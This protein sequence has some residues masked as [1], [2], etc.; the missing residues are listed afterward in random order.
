MKREP[1]A[2][3]TA[4]FHRCG[5]PRHG[6]EVSEGDAHPPH[7]VPPVPTP[8]FEARREAEL[9][10]LRVLAADDEETAAGLQAVVD[11]AAATF[12]C[13]L[14]VLSL[15]YSGSNMFKVAAGARSEG[16]P[17]EIPRDSAFCSH[18][19]LSGEQVFKV[20]DATGDCRF[21]EHPQVTE[22]GVRFY[23]GAP[24]LAGEAKQPIG[25]L[26]VVDFRQ[27]RPEGLSAR[28][29]AS[30]ATLARLASTQLE[31]RLSVMQHSEALAAERRAREEI[32]AMSARVREAAAAKAQLV[33]NLSHELRTPLHSVIGFSEL[34]AAELAANP[35]GPDAENFVRAVRFGGERLLETVNSMLSLTKLESGM[36]PRAHEAGVNLPELLRRLAGL[37]AANAARVPVVCRVDGGVPRAACL[38]RALLSQIVANL[39]GNAVK[40]ACGKSVCVA[41][42]FW[43]DRRPGPDDLVCRADVVAG[44][45]GRG[46]G[47]R[48]VLAVVRD[49]VSLGGAA[50]AAAAAGAASAC[51]RCSAPGVT[52]G[53]LALRVADSGEGIPRHRREAVFTPF[54]Q[55]S[56]STSRTHGGTGLGLSIT[57]EQVRVLGGDLYLETEAGEGTC[58]TVVLPLGVS[59][60][61]AGR[62]SE[63][64]G[65]PAE[66]PAPPPERR[67]RFSRKIVVAEDDRVAQR[68]LRHFFARLGLSECLVLCGDGASALAAAAEHRP[69]VLV[70]DQHMPVMGGREVFRRLRGHESPDVA[71][72]P[73]VAL[74]A[75]AFDEQRLELLE[76]GFSDYLV[77][78]V[79]LARLAEALRPHQDDAVRNQ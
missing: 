32:E 66:E 55:A 57:R 29:T 53:Y 47:A 9:A 79:S 13:D 43:P 30:L 73:V 19:V 63:A 17:K 50:P 38:D 26:A 10:R 21:R 33:A 54:E 35:A 37:H 39:V 3:R 62:A 12:D 76:L 45:A 16:L 77:K 31:L 34:L 18:A 5:G 67:L 60:A 6:K 56:S 4:V 52:T 71:S 1:M 46:G 48:D 41:A 49:G 78:P 61:C 25:V 58:F 72:V 22:G 42:D 14:A 40:F 2:M 69:A 75:D 51:A 27:G 15:T 28:E 24:V 68:L 23:A 74:T 36:A 20:C 70:L 8:E 44:V 65:A 59:P 64:A 11:A 7:L